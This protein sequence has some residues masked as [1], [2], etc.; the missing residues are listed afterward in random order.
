MDFEDLHLKFFQLERCIEVHNQTY[1]QTYIH[2]YIHAYKHTYIHTYIHA[3]T[4]SYTH[5]LNIYPS[6]HAEIY[7][8]IQADIHTHK[9]STHTQQDQMCN[10]YEHFL[11]LGLEGHMFASQWFLT[12]F[13]AKFPLFLV[14][15]ILDLFFSEVWRFILLSFF[16]FLLFFSAFIN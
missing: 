11:D 1:K 8:A 4:H 6:I 14:F 9:L 5:T 15:S 7:P 3:Y 13:T 2:T 16:F 12:L 10:L